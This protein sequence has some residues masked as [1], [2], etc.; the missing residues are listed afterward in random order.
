MSQR[1]WLLCRAWDDGSALD[2]VAEVLKATDA[3]CYAAPSSSGVLLKIIP[4]CADAVG[5]FTPPATAVA[6]T[7]DDIVLE[8]P[9]SDPVEAT[10]T[11]ES[12]IVTVVPV[13][14]APVEAADGST[15][16]VE[17]MEVARSTWGTLGVRRGETLSLPC[18]PL[19]AHA[20]QIS[21]IA[22]QR[23][24]YN[25]STF[26]WKSS[27]R[28]IGIEP[29][30]LV[31][32]THS[33]M[34][35]SG[36]VVRIQSVDE[37]DDGLEFEATEWFPGTSIVATPM[38]QTSDGL[39]V[40]PLV[41]P[42]TMGWGSTIEGMGND[43]VLS[44]VE[45]TMAFTEYVTLNA[46]GASARSVAVGYSIGVSAW[47][48]AWAALGTY[49]GGISPAWNDP[50]TGPSTIVGTDWRAAWTVAYQALADLQGVIAKVTTGLVPQQSDNLWPNGNSEAS[51][52]TGYTPGD[53]GDAQYGWRSYTPA[54]SFAGN[55]CRSK[56]SDGVSR[57]FELVLDLAAMPGDQHYLEAKALTNMTAG[58]NVYLFIRYFNAAG[59][60]LAEAITSFTPS[61]Y[62]GRSVTT[63]A[64]PA[65][66]TTVRFCLGLDT[67]AG[68]IAG[69][70]AF[71]DAIYARKMVG[72]PQIIDGAISFAKLAADSISTSDYTYTGT[73]GAADEVATQGARMRN[74]ASPGSS[75][76]AIVASPAGIKIGT[77]TLDAT[78]LNQGK[79]L[80]VHLL[81][82]T[83]T[84]SWAVNVGLG[85]GPSGAAYFVSSSIVAVATGAAGAA[86]SLVG[87]GLKS[88]DS[89]MPIIAGTGT[90]DA[91]GYARFYVVKHGAAAN[92]V[93]TDLNSTTW[94]LHLQVLVAASSF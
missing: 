51:P 77:K 5:T 36:Q 40:N 54:Y 46:Q 88:T 86:Y 89:I 2:A 44:P 75:L 59:G 18:I 33:V 91:N 83:G 53:G 78:W 73:L 61:S 19:A 23:S 55:Y 22:A 11:P 65:G 72:G 9:D 3:T 79:V 82:V 25:R 85:T 39:A 56:T 17:A 57:Y 8:S 10:R 34:G 41:P 43:N 47:D 15:A 6:L 7:D 93:L 71:F 63:A 32:L 58:C 27:W 50:T 66:T 52:P 14:Y 84:L 26:R 69:Y 4:M 42:D 1:G 24:V 49:L 13:E 35:L 29:G 70:Q 92:S 20:R 90:T 12:D 38:P 37:T 94:D 64:A 60:Q 31:T 76:P 62:S 16:T 30:D 67:G 68:R 81:C 74:N 87:G 45:K 21:Q 28:F 80:G 48:A